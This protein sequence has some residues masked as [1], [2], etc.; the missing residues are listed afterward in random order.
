MKL[1]DF[2]HLFDNIKDGKILIGIHNHYMVFAFYRSFKD[3][4]VYYYNNIFSSHWVDEDTTFMET[5]IDIDKNDIITDF[6]NYDMFLAWQRRNIIADIDMIQKE[7]DS[8][9]NFFLIKK[10]LER[11][12]GKIVSF[13]P[14]VNETGILI[15][16]TST[17]EDYYYAF[18][19]SE[20]KM[21]SMTCVSGYTV[22]DEENF[23]QFGTKTILD[24]I[25]NELAARGEV[26][27]TP[28]YLSNITPEDLTLFKQMS[29]LYLPKN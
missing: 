17:N 2:R 10:Q 11:D 26:F 29:F 1:N 27:F 16:A 20:G 18:I 23:P 5:E 8:H 13:A 4:K 25:M 9:P 14:N 21:K 7:P 6:I 3:N 22:A 15:G 24:K 12:G 19:T 28:I